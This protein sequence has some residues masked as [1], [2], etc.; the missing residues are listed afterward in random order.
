MK[1]KIDPLESEMDFGVRAQKRLSE[2]SVEIN[3]ILYSAA[4]AGLKVDIDT[5]Y[6]QEV[7]VPEFRQIFYRVYV[8]A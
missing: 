5:Q 4:K 8:P 7:G 3:N 6:M 2:L 1:R